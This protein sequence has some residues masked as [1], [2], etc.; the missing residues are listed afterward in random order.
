MT[1]PRKNANFW[2]FAGV[3]IL[4]FF[5]T[6]VVI[7]AIRVIIDTFIPFLGSG[8]SS[9]TALVMTFGGWIIA[10]FLTMRFYA[11]KRIVCKE[12]A[13]KV[14]ERYVIFFGSF[15]LYQTLAF[16]SNSREPFIPLIFCM[17][18]GTALIFIF[19]RKFL[20][21]IARQQAS[22]IS[23]FN[24]LDLTIYYIDPSK[25]AS[26]PISESRLISELHEQKIFVPSERLREYSHLISRLS[27]ID[28]IAVENK[29]TLNAKIHY[30]ISDKDN[31]E[32][33]R[34]SMWG[35]NNSMFVN[36]NEV[37]GEPLLYEV[38]IPFLPDEIARQL[39]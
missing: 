28:L 11:R 36:G 14:S 29:S 2:V 4:L 17:Y 12:F 26:I 38:I 1:M 19:A 6:I 16:M 8:V 9:M 15:S 23:K 21:R 37:K 3:N 7:V 30:V 13:N 34:V 22:E 27:H 31:A 25:S 32:V 5:L 39:P 20:N 35:D 33:F 18:L 10:L 24:G